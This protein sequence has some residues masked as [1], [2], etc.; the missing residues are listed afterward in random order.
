MV[1]FL[2]SQG[3]SIVRIMGSHHI[4]QRGTQHTSPVSVRFI[5][6]LLDSRTPKYPKAVTGPRTPNPKCW[7]ES[8]LQISHW[9]TLAC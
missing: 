6:F 9:F 1:R 2:Q 7:R 4:M 3:F 5:P 8:I